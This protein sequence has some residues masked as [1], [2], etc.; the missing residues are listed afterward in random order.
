LPTGATTVVLGLAAAMA[1]GA[2]DFGGGLASRRAAVYGVVLLSQL[3][4]MALTFIVAL[5]RQEPLPAGNDLVL[6]VVAGVFGGIGITALYRGLAVGRMGIVAPITGVL[7][8]LIPV[9][10]GFVIDGLPDAPVVLGIAVAIVAVVLVSRVVDEGGGRA[11]L[12]E[13]LVAGVAIGLFGVV[14]SQISE[15]AVFSA[16]TT[17]RMVQVALVAGVVIGLRLPWRLDR[18]VLLPVAIIGA[19]DIAGNA[20]YLLAV[21]SGPLAVA[22]ILSSLYPVGTVILA[23]VLLR[24]RIS[25]HHA[26]GIVLAAVAIALIGAGSA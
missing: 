16:L 8:A 13:A 12:P 14:I 20:F 19:L 21:Q 15:G 7:A 11:G 23:A 18:G 10:V 4:G 6:C 22:A 3:V 26:V 17:I 5:V 9:A 25:R 1:W 2:G 24:E